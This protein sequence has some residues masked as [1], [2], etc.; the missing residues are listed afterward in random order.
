[1]KAFPK[2]MLLL[3]TLP[4]ISLA[5][6]APVTIQYVP[7]GTIDQT[8]DVYWPSSRATATVLFIH[9]GSLQESGERRTAQMYKNVC[10]QFVAH[11]IACASMDYR[12]APKS[13]WPAM[14]QDVA[15]AVASLRKLLADGKGDPDQLFLFGH[16]SGCHLAAI[17]GMDST[18]LKSVGLGTRNIGGIIPMGCTLDRDDATLRG[19]TADRIRNAFM[20]E[21]QDVATYKS[22]EAYLNANPATHIGKHVPPTLIIVADAERFMPPIMEQGARV[23]R[24]LLE[25]GVAAN[26]VIVPGTHISSIEAV[27]KSDDPALLAILRF[28]ANPAGS[29][30]A[31]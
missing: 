28:I 20:N 17:V 15:Y 24:R 10:T 8:M 3:A 29:G 4:A 6:G 19:L 2:V 5:Q 21:A 16:S 9:G 26:L 22:A 1:M 18:Y 27:S 23:V 25:E 12:L 13:S 14:P 30:A 31:H 7:N 11:G